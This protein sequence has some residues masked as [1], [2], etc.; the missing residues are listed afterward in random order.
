MGRIQRS[1]TS[2]YRLT[3]K[4]SNNDLLLLL[5]H[6]KDVAKKRLSTSRS[7]PHPLASSVTPPQVQNSGAAMNAPHNSQHVASSGNS[8]SV[9]SSHSVPQVAIRG[10][11]NNDE[12]QEGIMNMTLIRD[13]VMNGVHKGVQ[14]DVTDDGLSN[15]ES[16]MNHAKSVLSKYQ[17][18]TVSND[19]YDFMEVDDSD[20][21]MDLE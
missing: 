12:P 7:L 11:I 9:P 3:K 6:R 8:H 5:K 21:P 20:F 18:V 2:A 4:N 17:N 1:A 19:E 13:V 16:P 10:S 14:V 15:H